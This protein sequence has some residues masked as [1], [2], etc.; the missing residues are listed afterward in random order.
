MVY[1]IQKKLCLAVSVKKKNRELILDL[2]LFSIISRFRYENEIKEL[3]N[4][5]KTQDNSTAAAAYN[6]M[7]CGLTKYFK[8]NQ[9]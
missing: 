6:I 4:F 8:V 3:F 1:F 7:I 9:S 2:I 5:L